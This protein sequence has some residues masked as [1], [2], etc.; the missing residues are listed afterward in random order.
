MAVVGLSADPGKSGAGS[1]TLRRAITTRALVGS[2]DTE[3]G[4]SRITEPARLWQQLLS[5]PSTRHGLLE[6][7]GQG[8][9]HR[10]VVA[11]AIQA[12][13]SQALYSLYVSGDAAPTVTP[14]DSAPKLSATA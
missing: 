13:G 8:G 7:F 2:G 11:S 1:A 4:V 12:L 6:G 10:D 14:F 9:V 3:V 5:N